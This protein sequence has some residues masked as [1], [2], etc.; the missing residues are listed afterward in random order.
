MSYPDTSPDAHSGPGTRRLP[1]PALRFAPR[2]AFFLRALVLLAVP[3]LLLA[4]CADEGPVAP[5][6]LDAEALDTEALAPGW[7]A[8]ASTGRPLTV[9]SRNLYLGGDISPL[10][11][12][13]DLGEAAAGI[14]AQIQLTEYPT[15]AR[16]LARE[17]VRAGADLVGLQEVT[18]FDLLLD[19][20]DGGLVPLPPIHFLPLLLDELEALGVSYQAAVE[21]RGTRVTVPV[22]LGEGAPT[23]LVTYEDG[24]AILVRQ[25][26]ETRNEASG[27]YQA[28]PPPEFTAGVPFVRGWS[29]TEARVSGRW[30]RFVNTHLEV[31]DLWPWQVQQT[32]E[33]LAQVANRAMPVI[34]VGDMNSA[35]N[36]SAPPDRKTPTYEMILR[37][38]FDDLWLRGKKA[39]DG[40]LTCCH[41][42]SLDN[43]VATFDQ[44]IDFVFARNVPSG[45]GFAGSAQVEVVGAHP[46]DRFRGSLGQPL[47]PSDHAGLVARLRLPVGLL[48]A[49]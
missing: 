17:I 12:G 15:R 20:G 22:S 14:W 38:G 26:V 40:G 35:A 6:A 18:N 46:T 23:I 34:L 7:A 8:S 9:M 29:S 41:D 5:P 30:V 42:P 37:A 44:R 4:G 21:L 36:P 11:D 39:P 13:G 24:Q 48:D 49:R 33:L 19:A 10:L 31:Q 25:G 43:P 2:P 1:S 28:A 45:R 32:E 16:A 47:W 27:L 3:A